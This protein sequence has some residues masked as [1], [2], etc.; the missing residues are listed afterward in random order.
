M[1][2]TFNDDQLSFHDSVRA[3]LTNQVTPE[4]LRE[5][6]DSESGRSD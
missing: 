5:L 2:F 6:W 1:D 3:F 4:R